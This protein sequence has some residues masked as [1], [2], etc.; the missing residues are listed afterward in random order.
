MPRSVLLQRQFPVMPNKLTRSRGAADLKSVLM[1]GALAL[2]AIA[3]FAVI[4]VNTPQ[5]KAVRLVAEAEEAI[6]AGQWRGAAEKLRDAHA[7]D[8]SVSGANERFD[9]MVRELQRSGSA[10]DLDSITDIAVDHFLMVPGA[11]A[12]L[13]AAALTSA[14][15]RQSSEPDAALSLLS[16]AEALDPSKQPVAASLRFMVLEQAV[17]V[18]PDT[19]RFAIL[20]APLREERDN[21][22]DCAALLDP[23]REVIRRDFSTAPAARILGQLDLQRGDLISAFALLQPYVESELKQLKQVSDAYDVLWERLYDEEVDL[24]NQN[25][26]PASFYK[27]W[28]AASAQDQPDVVDAYVRPRVEANPQM[29]RMQARW[30]AVL[31]VVPVAM[32]V[33]TLRL[34][35]ALEMEDAAARQMELQ[36]A[37]KAFLAVQ[38]V[39]GESVR[40]RKD[41]AQVYYWLGKPK[42][43]DALFDALLADHPKD[44]DLLNDVAELYRELGQD[45]KS[46]EINIKA[47]E[48]AATDEQRFTI[49]RVLSSLVYELDDRLHWLERSDQSISSVRAARAEV[50]AKQALEAGDKEK[51]IGFY[52]ESLAAI[53]DDGLDTNSALANN[54]SLSAFQLYYL[55]GDA[56]VLAKARQYSLRAAELAP[57]NGI[58]LMNSADNLIQVAL[59]HV[60]RSRLVLEQDGQIA[61]FD[62]SR[63]LWSDADERAAA[64]AEFLAEPAV[65]DG[66]R[67]LNNALVLRPSD[68]DL[69]DFAWDYYYFLRS[70]EDLQ[71]VATQMRMVGADRSDY[72]ATARD[73]YLGRSDDEV[74]ANLRESAAAWA[75]LLPDSDPAGFVR[76]LQAEALVDHSE[77]MAIFD[78]PIESDAFLERAR[79]AYEDQP[80]TLSRAVLIDAHM[81]KVYQDLSQMTSF[82]KLKAGCPRCLGPRSNVSL[83]SLRSGEYRERI[84]NNEHAVRAAALIEE[85]VVLDRQQAVPF[86]LA[87][88]KAVGSPMVEV[89]D[90]QLRK[91]AFYEANAQMRISM[92]PVSV[93]SVYELALLASLK[94]DNAKANALI[95]AHEAKG[96]EMIWW[97][98]R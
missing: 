7:L 85:Q 14:E 6:E 86:D 21:C 54:Y 26:G 1:I 56:A 23:H 9:K 50:Q 45:E 18:R 89:L 83:A 24:L 81:L 75:E 71:R 58:V 41:L 70:S 46:Y 4:L 62:Y 53:E 59:E 96:F 79:R 95:D 73:Y 35:R 12:A 92:N 36:A 8:D 44:V 84:R 20:L 19:P 10:G 5:F 67:L 16:Q 74:R 82:R 57:S 27:E 88:L 97:P 28:E 80:S 33:G 2:I 98:R 61:N 55:T 52:R 69:Y 42:E 49:A 17:R 72:A 29:Q 93:R 15:Q 51:A 13:A 40:Y 31:S 76:V 3:L 43:G 64:I 90:R 32:D 11:S 38:G 91:G 78:L 77:E 48:M 65:A 22:A 68:A 37:E 47:Y 39:A 30:E 94:G 60:Q 25:V 63:G 66:Q 34:Y 87:L